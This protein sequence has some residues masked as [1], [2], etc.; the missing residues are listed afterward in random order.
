LRLAR[1]KI[2]IYAPYP[3]PKERFETAHQHSFLHPERIVGN[4]EMIPRNVGE[5]R[6]LPPQNNSVKTFPWHDVRRS[7]AA[8]S[9]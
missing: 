6:A 3:N 1:T 4:P 9:V 8:A 7:Q 5:E 2:S